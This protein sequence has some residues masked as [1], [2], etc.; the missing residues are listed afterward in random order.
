MRPVAPADL[1]EAVDW[2]HRHTEGPVFLESNLRFHGLADQSDHPRAVWLWAAAGGRG[3][4]GL[5]RAGFL[6]PQMRFATGEDST[7][8]AEALR[9]RQIAG[10][11]GAPDQVSQ[12]LAPTGMTGRATTLDH[13]EPA[14][15]L[16]LADLVMP[17]VAG[18]AARPI[19]EEDRARVV[20]W[21]TDYLTIT[22]GTPP[23]AAPT[24]AA[25]EID[26][27]MQADSHRVLWCEGLPVGFTGFDARLPDLVQIG[28]VYTPPALRGQGIARAA[29]ALHLAKAPAQGVARAA[30]FVASEAAARADRAIGFRAAG[31]V[32]L[33]TFALAEMVT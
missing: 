14:F 1:P 33:V 29:V 4:L 28:G 8:A 12:A 2:L 16:D 17:A 11:N 20:A 25:Q 27:Y 21:R 10:L 13:D 22:M 3:Y 9:G 30:L 19:R 31:R 23:E 18:V 5:S 32:R 7:A 15:E 26:G 24:Q 6:M